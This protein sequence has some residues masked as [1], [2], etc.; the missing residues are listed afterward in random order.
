MGLESKMTCSEI[1]GDKKSLKFTAIGYFWRIYQTLS[2]SLL[3]SLVMKYFSETLVVVIET[4]D[5]SA[6]LS[7]CARGNATFPSAPRQLRH[8]STNNGAGGNL[9]FFQRLSYSFFFILCKHELLFFSIGRCSWWAPD[10]MFHYPSVNFHRAVLT[11][12]HT[13]HVPRAPDFF[14][15]APTGCGEI[16]F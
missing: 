7:C 3:C 2:Y 14:W 13:G 10:N 4:T 8:C 9:G 6:P 16:I 1:T 12:G 5:I 15:G 11:N